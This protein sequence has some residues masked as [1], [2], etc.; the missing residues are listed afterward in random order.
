M[1]ESTLEATEEI[2]GGLAV[3]SLTVALAGVGQHDAE[4]VSLV[5][6][7]VGTDNW[8]ACAEVDLNLITGSA[9]E[10]AERELSRRLQA[11]DE[12][13]D[14]VVAAR[15]IVFRGEILVDALG[16]EA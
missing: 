14:A 4:D 1:A 2:V 3:D 9:L 5:A 6:L 8:G 10:P 12:T 16:T 11:M 15:E 13:T 7:A